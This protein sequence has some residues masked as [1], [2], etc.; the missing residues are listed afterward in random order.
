MMKVS[1]SG[2]TVNWGLMSG[3]AGTCRNSKSL[4]DAPIWIDG[5]VTISTSIKAFPC[6]WNRRSPRGLQRGTA[7]FLEATCSGP[8]NSG[9]DRM[10]TAP[11]WSYASQL[12]SG[13]IAGFNSHPSSSRIGS[14]KPRRVQK[15][16][17]RRICDTVSNSATFGTPPLRVR[18]R[19]DR[20]HD[21]MTTKPSERE[22]TLL[23]GLA[24]VVVEQ[25]AQALT[26]ANGGLAVLDEL[27]RLD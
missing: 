4:R 3:N 7:E 14:P 27:S 15:R 9:Y 20:D 26:T 16:D 11:P 18:P 19:L 23:R 25:P 2:P 13:E 10:K 1:P 17:R 12:P 5:L 8:P 21:P 6:R 24:V 22:P